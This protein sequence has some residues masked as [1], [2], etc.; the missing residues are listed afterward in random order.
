MNNKSF[1]LIETLTAIVIIGLL[2]GFIIVKFQ[3]SNVAAEISRGKAFSLSLLTSLPIEM[4]SEWKFDGPTS[5]GS[6]ATTDDVKDTWGDN[7]GTVYGTPLVKDGNDCISGKCIYFNGSTDYIGYGNINLNISNT[8][9]AAA[10]VKFNNLDYIGSSGTLNTIFAKGNP[11]VASGTPSSG[12]WFSYDNRNN[13]SSFSYTCFGNSNGG[14]SG[15]GNNFS[16]SSYYYKFFNNKWYYILFTIDASSSGKLYI[17]GL[18]LGP[19][20]I[21]SNLV[22]SNTTNNFN[23]GATSN[24]SHKI[25]GSLDDIRIFNKALIVSQINQA[26][27][28]GLNNLYLNN[29]ISKEEYNQRLIE[30]NN[31]LVKHE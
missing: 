13:A 24:T 21:F 4:V 14:Y 31:N 30:L 7:N 19:T 25:N 26:Y 6:S 11:D 16:S 28:S 2:A 9:T 22:L 23:I 27:L 1:T 15:G 20:K 5:A 10:W 29:Q 17:N 3:D 18:Q 8:M 12:F